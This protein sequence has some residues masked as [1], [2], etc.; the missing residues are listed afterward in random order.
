MIPSAVFVPAVALQTKF[1]LSSKY[2]RNLGSMPKT[3]APVLLTSRKHTTGFLVNSFGKRCRSTVLTA[4]CCWRSSQCIPAQ[5]FI[6]AGGAKSPPFNIGVG[7][8]Q[9]CMLSPLPFIVYM[10]W[11]RGGSR[12]RLVRSSPHKTYQSNFF[13]HDFEQFRKQHSRFKAILSSTVLLQQWCEVHCVSLTVV[14]SQWDLAAKY[15]WNRPPHTKRTGAW[16]G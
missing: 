7:L 2:L 12:G 14:N 9:G 16:I 1:S 15:N 4:A 6:H 11:I 13:H 8:R 10:S 5:T 3:S